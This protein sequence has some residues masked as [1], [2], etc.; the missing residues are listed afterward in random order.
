MTRQLSYDSKVTFRSVPEVVDVIDAMYLELARKL[1]PPGRNKLSREAMQNAIVLAIAAMPAAEREDAVRRGL[2]RLGS[3]LEDDD[4][5]G[6][7]DDSRVY[8]A[9]PATGRPLG[10]SKRRRDGTD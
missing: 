1:A 2:V 5:A 10:R 7:A 8:E 3:I 6:D 9:D 4:L